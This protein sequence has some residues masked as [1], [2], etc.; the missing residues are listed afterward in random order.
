MI[1]DYV[2]SQLVTDVE[3]FL[4]LFYFKKPAEDKKEEVKRQINNKRTDFHFVDEAKKT[5]NFEKQKEKF[6]FDCGL[7]IKAV[8]ETNFVRAADVNKILYL[9]FFPH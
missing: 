6:L 3:K 8:A 1:D 7:Q 4:L 5:Q 9:C 2:I